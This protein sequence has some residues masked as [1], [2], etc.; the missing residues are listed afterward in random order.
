MARMYTNYLNN[1]REGCTWASLVATAIACRTKQWLTCRDVAEEIWTRPGPMPPTLMTQVNAAL[2]K[3]IG[4]KLVAYRR[5]QGQPDGS[6]Y[7][8]S[9][10]DEGVDRF[11]IDVE[12][13]DAADHTDSE[14]F[15]P[16]RKKKVQRRNNVV[17]FRRVG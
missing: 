1:G 16:S 7:E 4:N 13:W 10:S 15:T 14:L 17:R 2:D 5:N 9:L 8:Y 6:R 3:L 12:H 11:A